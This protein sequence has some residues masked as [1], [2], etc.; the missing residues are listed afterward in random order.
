MLV[1]PATPAAVAGAARILDEAPEALSGI[2][3]VMP[4]PPMPF[5]PEEYHG[6]TVI[7]AMLCYA[8]PADEAAPA[9]APVRALAEP[10]ADMVRP[11]R[12]P[13]MYPPDDPD[14]HPLAVS[15]TYF[16]DTF[17]EAEGRGR[18]RPDR[19]PDDVADPRAPAAAAGR[20][21][22]ARPGRRHGL[23]P[24]AATVH[25]QRGGVLR[26][27]PTTSPRS[28]AWVDD[29]GGALDPVPGAY[30]NFVADEGEARV[31]EAYPAATWE[32]LAADQAAL[33]PGQ[34]VPPQPE[35]PARS[36]RLMGRRAATRRAALPE[37]RRS[38]R[39]A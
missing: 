17:D 38:A 31:H 36:G 12:Y 35:R 3:N 39:A 15:K 23:R 20:R 34:P 1:L 5:V 2:L 22:G 13:E 21:G 11:I 19:G 16:L 6:S 18:A 28:T 29:L 27:A 25:G 26:R 33:R 4:C 14:Y 10:L 7:M 32:R 24:P 37:G 9:L 8:G 30:V